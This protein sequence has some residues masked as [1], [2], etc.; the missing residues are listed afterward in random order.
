MNF[1]NRTAAI[2]EGEGQ[3]VILNT[4]QPQAQKN[5]ICIKEFLTQGNRRLLKET[6]LKSE[7]ENL[8][9]TA[10]LYSRMHLYDFF[11]KV[12]L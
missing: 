3:E 11:K 6:R 2:Q 12:K 7:E 1:Y 9:I 5:C 8:N 10:T 4:D